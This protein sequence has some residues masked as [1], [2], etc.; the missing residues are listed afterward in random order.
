[1]I[2]ITKN[3][4]IHLLVAAAVLSGCATPGQNEG[5][6]SNKFSKDVPVVMFPANK[7]GIFDYRADYRKALCDIQESHGKSLLNSMPCEKALHQLGEET[8]LRLDHGKMPNPHFK[9]SVRIVV[10]PGIFGECAI[11]LVPPLQYARQHLESHG[12]KTSLANVSGRSG[13]VFNAKMI[14][15]HINSDLITSSEKLIFIGYS[16]GSVD[17]L[18]AVVSYPDLAS[19]TLAVVSLAGPIS[20]TPAADKNSKLYEKI[21]KKLKL[22][23]CAQGDDQGVQSLRTNVRAKWLHDNALP[24]SIDYYSL[25]AFTNKKNISNILKDSYVKLSKEDKRNDSNVILADA[26]IPGARLLGYAN[27]D[28]WAIALPF[29]EN[30][31]FLSKTFVNKNAFPRE[32]MLEAII[33]VIELS[34]PVGANV[35]RDLVE[36]GRTYGGVD[37]HADQMF[38]SNP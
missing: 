31:K 24:S 32:A 13:P 8:P 1:M 7:A 2:D 14:Y 21:A 10:I 37:S 9:Q 3:L 29:T 35:Q 20:G 25:V 22:K 19:Q 17:A 33:R 27:A 30:S 11:G 38:A 4:R 23:T 5:E 36:H 15:D 34:T 12:Y 26:V 16:K 6:I 18:Q 28:H